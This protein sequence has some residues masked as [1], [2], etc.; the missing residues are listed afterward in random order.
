MVK[1]STYLNRRVF[2]MPKVHDPPH[3]CLCF[4]IALGLLLDLVNIMCSQH[5]IKLINIVEDLLNFPYFGLCVASDNENRHLASPLAGYY[6]YQPVCESLFLGFEDLW[7][8]WL[9]VTGWP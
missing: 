7:V 3:S 5:F 8:F 6:Q 1:F 9:T 4:Y 2:V